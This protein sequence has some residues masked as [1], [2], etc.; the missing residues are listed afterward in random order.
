MM[1][2]AAVNISQSP[3]YYFPYTFGYLFAL[4]IYAKEKGERKDFE[5]DYMTLLFD[6]GLYD[7]GIFGF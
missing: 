7:D 4:S 6:P 3:F 1:I 5:K 2:L